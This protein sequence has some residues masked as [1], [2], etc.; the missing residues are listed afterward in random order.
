M[1]KRDIT[2]EDYDGQTVTETFYF[3]ITKSELVELEVSHKKGFAEAM[4][5]IIKA[6]DNKTLIA[7]FKKLVLLAHGVKSDDGKR[8]IK[9][10]ESR[11]EFSQTAAYNALFMEI[12]T[13]DD[14]AVEFIQGIL[15]KDMTTGPNGETFKEL[16]DAAATTP[17]S[18]AGT[19]AA[20]ASTLASQ[21]TPASIQTEESVNEPPLG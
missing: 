4:Q 2:Y 19:T 1:L 7:E 3:N 16:V 13:D 14:A 11:T 10:D 21:P 5:D 20:I 8:F 6:N 9:S 12:A 15:P 17:T 18:N